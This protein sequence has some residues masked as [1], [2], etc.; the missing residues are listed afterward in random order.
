VI[1]PG[2]ATRSARASRLRKH[3]RWP[4]DSEMELSRDLEHDSIARWDIVTA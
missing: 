3:G 4:A 2:P 1:L